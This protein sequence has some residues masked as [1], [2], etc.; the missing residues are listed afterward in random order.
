MEILKIA[1]IAI[2]AAAAIAF[3]KDVK[4]EL[5]VFAGVAAGV[6]IFITVADM[7]TA[8]IATVTGL[9]GKT[10]IQ[11]ELTASVLKIIGVGYIAEFAAGVCED[12]GNKGLGDKII[13]GGKVVILFLS[14]PILKGLL[15]VIIALL[16]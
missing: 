15:D 8:I 11:P 1:G 13:F 9:V 7:L 16:P 3:L 4:P 2:V 12:S 5:A 6:L 14:L 10:G